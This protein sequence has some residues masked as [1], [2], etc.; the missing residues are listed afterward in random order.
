MA[1]RYGLPYFLEDKSGRLSGSDFIDLHDR[2]KLAYSCKDRSSSLFTYEIHDTTAGTYDAYN[3]AVATLT[4]GSD[5]ALGTITYTRDKIE[6]QMVDYLAQVNDIAGSKLRRFFAS[7]GKEYRWGYRVVPNEEWTCTN[8]SGT[9]V[10]HYNLK[11]DG[12]PPYFGSSGC[13]LSVDEDF[14]HLA[15]EMLATVMI[16]RHID[17]HNL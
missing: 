3:K 17:K 5:N 2:M 16:M 12:E 11:V 8:S 13:M 7:D 9:V 6:R 14:G 4:F 15:C 10:S 1:L